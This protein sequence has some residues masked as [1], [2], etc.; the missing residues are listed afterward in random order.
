[1]SVT[2]VQSDPVGH[3]AKREWRKQIADAVQGGASVAEAA[4]KFGGTLQTV[5]NAC[6][7]NGVAYPGMR[8]SPKPDVQRGVALG[9]R[10]RTKSPV[11][12][13]RVAR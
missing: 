13:V 4:R 3:A 1:M 11:L 9:K 5:R 8:C 12:K 10:S 7:E 6:R 2:E